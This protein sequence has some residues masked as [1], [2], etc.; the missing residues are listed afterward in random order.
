MRPNK[1]PADQIT[2]DNLPDMIPTGQDRALEGK[3]K[4]APLLRSNNEEIS[5]AAIINRSPIIASCFALHTS[6]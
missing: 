5:S 2:R 6:V 1:G 3:G 4:L